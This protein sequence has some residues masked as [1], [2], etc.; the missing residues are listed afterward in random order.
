M[1]S[2]FSAGGGD[3]DFHEPL[4]EEL[5]RRRPA[6]P[7]PVPGQRLGGLDGNRYE[8][9]ALLGG[10]GM[11]QVF[12]ALDHELRRTVALKFLHFNPRL[13]APAWLLLLRTEAQAIARLDHENIVRIHDV[14]EWKTGPARVPFLVM[15]YLEGES[16]QALLR[17]ERPG[18]ARTLDI[19]RDVAAGLAHAHERHLVHRDLKPANIFI[20]PNGRAKLLDFGLALLAVGPSDS[21]LRHD[22]GTPA[23]MAPEQWR[24]EPADARADIWAAG[25]L[26]FELLTGEPPLPRRDL[27]ELRHLITS[28]QPLPSLHQRRPELPLELERLVASMLDKESARRPPTGAELLRKVE[29]LREQLAPRPRGPP[30]GTGRRQ[31]TLLACQLVLTQAASLPVDSEESSELEDRFHRVCAGLL[32]QSGGVLTAAVGAEVLACF[33]YPLMHEADTESA[34]RTALHLREAVRR[35]LAPLGPHGVDVRMG[36]HTDRVRLAPPLPEQHGTTPA[37]QGEA[38]R[39]ARWLAAQARPGMVLLSDQTQALVRGSVHTRPLGP[40]SFEGLSGSRSLGV[41]QALGER[42]AVTRFERA[43][44]VGELTPL[45]GREQ[46]LR[47]LVTL[48]DEAQRGGG[49]FCLLRGEAG[50]GKSRLVQE[51]LHREH[52]AQSTWVRCQCW[53]QFTSSAFSPFLEWLQRFLDFAQDDALPRKREKLEERLRGLDVPA[54]HLPPLASLLSLPL[55]SRDPFSH[56]G[57]ERQ[58]E[59]RLKA[60]TALLQQL[61]RHC[62]L[63]LVVEDLH[64]ADPSTL[65]FL[66]LLLEQPGSP[67]LWGLLTA[68]PEFTPPWRGHP[69]FQ[70]LEV[71]A[72]GAEATAAL[73]RGVARDRTLPA[74]TVAQL[75]ARTDGI[76]LFI[77]ELTRMMLEQPRAEGGAAGPPPSSI[78][79]TL[80][81]LLL[82]RLDQLPPQ[83]KALVQLAATVG[84]EFS[85]DLL[86]AISFLPEGELLTELEQLEQ[87]GLLFRLGPPPDTTYAFKH[88]LLQD[89]AYQSLLRGTR[90]Q[91]HARLVQVLSEQFPEYEEDQPELLALH[92]TRA[93][94][95][96]QAVDYWQRAG[97]QDGAKS[98]LPEALNHFTRALEQLTLLPASRERDVRELALLCELGQVLVSTHGFA[99]RE[100]EDVFSRARRLCEQPDDLPLPV[101]WGLWN[102]ALVRADSEG[103]ARLVPVFQHLLA[104]HEEP[105]TLI[106]LHGALACWSFW[107]GDY[108]ATQE[109]GAQA[110]A[111]LRAHQLPGLLEEIRGG[112]QGYVAE[113]L[114]YAHLYQALSTLLLGQA[115][116]ARGDYEEA[117]AL[118][119]VM[120]HP[121]AMVTALMF[122]ATLA[123][124][125]DEPGRAREVAGRA[126]AISLENGFPFILAD[127]LC[128][129]GWATARLGEAEAGIASLQ[130]GLGMLRAMG[131][132][133][134]YPSCLLCLAK[135]CL[136][137]GQ[138][139][140]GLAAAREGLKLLETNL[141]RYALPELLHLQGELLL[142]QG[143]E[144]AARA[145]LR[146]A[147]ATARH[148]GPPLHELRA[149]TGLARYLQRTGQPREARSLLGAACGRFTEGFDLNDYQAAREL[150]AG[151]G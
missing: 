28:P 47:R 135:A 102:N 32:H 15:E 104:T 17:R 70:V 10:G 75:V 86:R 96:S 128:I 108:R 38:P 129:H 7:L 89:A 121:Y 3:S 59:R 48:R 31:V 114:L 5:T 80:N 91:Y 131:A 151:L 126:M 90:Q 118:A 11:G 20:L 37:M 143:E 42:K 134:I 26:L 112:R 127:S 137:G 138:V 2:H 53:P 12:Q 123:C 100:V 62:P 133:L 85:H 98:A 107:R 33:G 39:I 94:L 150:L 25:L 95:T 81:E 19:M 50:I 1:N 144:E 77:E 61:A 68:R 22:A 9:V 120:H 148:L 76:P 101:L 35:E 6:V 29:A 106:V 44:V 24:G 78:P 147:V 74:E 99:A 79:A 124:E 139:P 105:C 46:E 43:F 73:A 115:D 34:V 41:H 52:A 132:M 117:L 82:A 92:A 21:P 16:L 18:L 23:Y 113:Q 72:L 58:R 36:L 116:R 130:Q 111:L 109:H 93:G 140:E 54:E 55:A 83:R 45:V 60:L 122:G 40:Q 141:G 51:L 8:I 67:P 27:Q 71:T 66:G 49:G 136:C 30:P 4:L 149:A 64:W 87:A 142:R 56:L 88:A 146:Q 97:E 69:R 119:E 63:V 84:R 103:T 110:R 13:A 14:S 57:P 125:A 145:S 65:Q